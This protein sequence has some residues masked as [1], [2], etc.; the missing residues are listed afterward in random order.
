MVRSCS[1]AKGKQHRKPPDW[2]QGQRDRTR[3]GITA[4]DFD[5]PLQST[6]ETDTDRKY[7]A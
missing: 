2:R 7:P 5:D 1:A 4:E 3:H 6:L